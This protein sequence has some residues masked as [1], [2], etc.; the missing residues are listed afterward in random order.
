M[1]TSSD[2]AVT[3]AP[4]VMGA[5]IQALLRSRSVA[6]DIWVAAWSAATG[7]VSEPDMIVIFR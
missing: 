6:S 2:A 4:L 5:T 3:A 7:S 1:I